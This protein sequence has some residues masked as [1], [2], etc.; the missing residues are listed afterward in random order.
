MEHFDIEK[1]N[2]D[3]VLRYRALLRSCNSEI[4]REDKKLIRKAFN[5]AVD[6]HKDVRRKSGEPYIF[7]PIAVAQIVAKDIGLDATAISCALLHDVVEDTEYTIEEMSR[8]FNPKVSQII[9][10]LTK[11]S[12]FGAQNSSAQA[13]NFRKM[14]LT[15]SDDVRVILIK[16]ADRLHNMQ[17]LESMPGQKQQ[18]IA[19]ETLYIYAPLA[20]R[21]G[22][23]SIKSELEDLGLKYTQPDI[24]REIARQLNETKNA[25]IQY[26]QKFIKPLKA[27]LKNHD[28][29]FS[30]KGR[31]KSIFSIR[32]KMKNQ[33]I[34]F[35]E[36]YDKFAIRIILNSELKREKSD[37]W[38]TY[39]LI[40]DH[41]HPNP[42]RLRDWIS[43]PK[44][45][46]YESLHTTLMGPAGKWVEVQIRTERMD[47]LAEKGF[48]AHW[49]YKQS[50]KSKDGNLEDWINQ[51]REL[52]EQPEVNALDFLEEFKLNLFSKEIFVF[53]PNGELKTLPRGASALDFAFEIHSQLGANCLGCKVNG[54]ITPLSHKLKSGDQVE[55]ISSLKQKPK[56][57]WLNFVVTA[58]AKN[59][60]KSSLKD[61][62]K[63]I[64][65]EGKEI[66]KR[67]LKH[68]KLVL[69]ENILK[70]LTTYYKYKSSFDLFYD[71]GVGIFNNAMIKE[72]AT[73]RNSWYQ[74]LK[75]KIYK[76]ASKT[77]EIKEEVNFDTLVFG[78]DEEKLN[79]TISKCCS[80]IP[81]DEVFGF[82][83]IREG[84][85][86]HRN[87][88]PNA[89]RLHANF[90][91]RILIAKWLDSSQIKSFAVLHIKGIDSVGLINQ[92]TQILSNTLKINIHS[93]NISTSDGTFDGNITLQV[94]DKKSLS[95]VIENIKKV[96]GITHVTRK[97]KSN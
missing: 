48:A 18:K 15:I 73:N 32:K 39:S 58:K 1:E 11:I 85:K 75:N 33:G 69:N 17:T 66:L 12:G 27:T 6:A 87:N 93:I 3:I 61:E 47:E 84:I 2:K 88:C 44:A 95:K 63:I 30:I 4:T 77:Q 16:L 42:D 83:T 26:I 8:L 79:Y 74:Y 94:Q 34:S 81:G 49:K 20:H 60:I 13:E 97:L 56:K 29:E 43:T 23:Y 41:Y 82:T 68:L 36:V 92:V 90:A 46:G 31:P 80:P 89:L 9:N 91:Y 10:G 52:L 96:S 70:E 50:G 78:P 21:L 37:C 22:L 86:I 38:K 67:K 45:N 76:R 19:S 53:T 24:Y 65:D 35:N 64:A 40:T 25:R 28:L 59:K 71:V 7:H 57:S 5:L 51:I 62:K 55:V 72:F 14:L 54:K